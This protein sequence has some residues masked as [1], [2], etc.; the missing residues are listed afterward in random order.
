MDGKWG[1]D[2]SAADIWREETMGVRAV[3]CEVAAVG[4]AGI[5]P[6]DASDGKGGVS[7]L[8]SGSPVSL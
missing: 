6:V 3:V 8:W 2:V 4:A 1:F 5:C 7:L